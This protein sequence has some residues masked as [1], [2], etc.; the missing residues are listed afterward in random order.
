[1]K[2][3]FDSSETE[4]FLKDGPQAKIQI[5]DGGHFALDAATGKIA[6]LVDCFLTIPENP[7]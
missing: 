6:N 3:S 1:M 7:A 5:V 2:L 4:A